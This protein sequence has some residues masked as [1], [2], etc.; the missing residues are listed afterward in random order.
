MRNGGSWFLDVSQIIKIKSK[1]LKLKLKLGI[2][3]KRAYLKNY[4]YLYDKP[5]FGISD[6]TK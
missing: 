6:N 4:D 1:Q 3:R 5:K 2:Y